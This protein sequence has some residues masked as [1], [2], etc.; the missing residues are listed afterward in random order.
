M[1]DLAPD[2]H[3]RP[4]R[5]TLALIFVA[6]ITLI[7]GTVSA[8]DGVFGGAGGSVA[9]LMETRV[10]MVS[11][12]IVMEVADRPDPWPEQWHVEAK[13][14]FENRSDEPVTL[15]V[16]F[17]ELPCMGDC[18][19]DNPYTFRGLE[20]TVRGEP[21]KHRIGKV[22]RGLK[23]QHAYGRIHLFDVTFA[24]HEQVVI[25][26]TYNHNLSASVDGKQA[27][28]VTTTG[29]YWNGPIG[30]AT[31]TVRA[32]WRHSYT[33]YPKGFVMTD[34]RET[35]VDGRRRWTY[36]FN[37]ERWVPKTNFTLFFGNDTERRPSQCPTYYEVETATDV[38]GVRVPPAELAQEAKKLYKEASAADLRI[39]RNWPY[40]LHGYPFKSADLRD[41]YYAKAV[42]THCPYCGPEDGGDQDEQWIRFY[43]KVN[44]D[45]SPALLDAEDA[46]YFRI[47]KVAEKLRGAHQTPTVTPDPAP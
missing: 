44:P 33:A 47:V 15:Q 17:P 7:A 13:Y 5:N 14:V 39:C 38:V 43:G 16:G 3:G 23:W 9:P 19:E 24:P 26:H 2:N 21:V 28:Y 10:S 6:A 36:V 46:R 45:F 20:T 25:A 1:Q 4:M 29:A 27:D 37:M 12:D 18:P 11:E 35:M 32:P 30:R 34:R 8:N 40:A 22:K 31:F 41:F 42:I